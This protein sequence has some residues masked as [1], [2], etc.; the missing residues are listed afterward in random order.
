MDP[1]TWCDPDDPIPERTIT[2]DAEAFAILAPCGQMFL[3]D[4]SWSWSVT[5]TLVEP[6]FDVG[7]SGEKNYPIFSPNGRL[8]L[9]RR[10]GVVTVVDVY[11]GVLGTLPFD[12]VFGFVPRPSAPSGMAAWTCRDGKVTVLD[13]NG[14]RMVFEEVDC[15]TV[16]TAAQAPVMVAFDREGYLVGA[17][18][19]TDARYE[20]EYNDADVADADN[21]R[22]YVRV[23]PDGRGVVIEVSETVFHGHTGSTT[24]VGLGVVEL[25][26]MTIL[27]SGEPVEVRLSD[28]G[29]G[30]LLSRGG[31]TPAGFWTS[32]NRL[33]SLPRAG[34]YEVLDQD[35]VVLVDAEEVGDD[36]IAIWNPRSEEMI[37]RQRPAS[38]A[39]EFDGRDSVAEITE[40]RPECGTEG[41]AS[42]GC[43]LGPRQRR[44][45]QPGH[46]LGPI[47]RIAA[48]VLV[49]TYST[50]GDVLTRRLLDAPGTDPQRQPPDIEYTAL[51]T[52]DEPLA[53]WIAP[54]TAPVAPSVQFVGADD[55]AA[56][57]LGDNGLQIGLMALDRGGPP[58][59]LTDVSGSARLDARLRVAL[60]PNDDEL[61]LVPTQPP[62]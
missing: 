10:P 20:T 7:R 22:R 17:D 37:Y 56:Y 39:W 11:D 50:E 29:H 61:T 30:L 31:D 44:L 13:P 24:A 46:G 8:A 48:D 52:D 25:P 23:T 32:D 5:N 36:S 1:R 35:H 19:E 28:D 42:L 49:S 18:L 43:E 41:V 21:R 33:V 16:T 55:R 38:F 60:G 9:V 54:S 4:A 51:G 2:V 40:L 45:W 27:A 58:R 15:D 57:L 3:A 14:G 59:R 26:N 53:T 62:R 34:R 6:A 47:R 12:E